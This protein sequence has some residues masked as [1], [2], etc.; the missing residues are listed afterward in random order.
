MK[1]LCFSAADILLPDFSVTDGRLWSCIACDQFTSEADYWDAV[2]REVGDAPSTLRIILPELYL[3]K[4]DDERISR[5][6]A[7]MEKYEKT[8]LRAHPDSMIYLR[9]LCPTGKTREGLIG[10]MDLEAYDY[11][12]TATSPVRATEGTVLSRIPPRVKVRRGARLEAPHVMILIDDAEDTV[13]SCIRTSDNTPAYDHALLEG[14]GR[15][16]GAFLSKKTQ[17]AVTEALS[18][19][20]EKNDSSLLFAVGDGNHSLASAKA[21]YEE[22]KASLGEEIARRHPARYALCEIVN[23]HSDALV[24]EP[25]Y[26]VVFGADRAEL[27]A[28]MRA[29]AA[30]QTEGAAQTVEIVWKEQDVCKEKFTFDHGAHSLTVGTLQMFLDE[31]VA[32]H[33]EVEVDYIHDE[34]SLLALSAKEG[35]V[36]FLFDGMRKEELFGAVDA[37]GALPR[38]TFS[39]GSAREKR[40][41]TE[42]RRIAE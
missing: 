17:T 15:V 42:C 28:A 16:T 33:P 20:S 31:Y 35:A 37:D 36:G 14:G 18:A 7:A 5:I 32:A 29:F 9:R 2:E 8:V 1:E 39:M 26:R 34:A 30:R 19:L 3:G 6:H 24:F 21:Y 4:E 12:K 13:F 38:K 25:I 23:I 41:Y 40:Y 11:S 10:K 22:L 27:L